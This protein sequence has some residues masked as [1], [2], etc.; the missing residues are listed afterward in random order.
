MVMDGTD[1]DAILNSL[2]TELDDPGV[3]PWGGASLDAGDQYEE[4]R[5]VICWC[6]YEREASQECGLPCA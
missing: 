3:D 5:Y 4:V 1:V 6:G 2:P